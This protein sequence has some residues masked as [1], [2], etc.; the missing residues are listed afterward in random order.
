MPTSRP[1][2]LP[3]PGAARRVISEALKELAGRTADQMQ[4][5]ANATSLVPYDVR[6]WLVNMENVLPFL[7][8]DFKAFRAESP[9]HG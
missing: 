5:H 4:H 3:D 8:G 2:G 9:F 7:P 1:S 6:D